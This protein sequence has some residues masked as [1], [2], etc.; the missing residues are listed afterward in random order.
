MSVAELS[1]VDFAA[2]DLS[3][4]LGILMD[5]GALPNGA[6]LTA[7][8]LTGSGHAFAGALPAG[9]SRADAASR[10]LGRTDPLD[11]EAIGRDARRDILGEMGP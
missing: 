3:E 4:W 2:I 9:H 6:E 5:A 11:I 10:A 1:G 8:L 7:E